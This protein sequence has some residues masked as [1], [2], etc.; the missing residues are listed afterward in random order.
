MHYTSTLPDI[1][2][3]R[4][5][6][7]D[8]WE[9]DGRRNIVADVGCLPLFDDPLRCPIVT[10]NAR[11]DQAGALTDVGV[12][13][14][15]DIDTT[16]LDSTSLDAGQARELA[17]M[18]LAAADLADTWTGTPVDADAALMVAREQLET[19]SRALRTQPGN[20]GCW[21]K[22]ALDAVTEAQAVLR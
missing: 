17:A 2:P 16:S 7:A 9:Q 22:A 19:A 10:T 20:A 5:A 12:R 6:D 15:V 13:L 11:Q 3:P 8:V 18:L 4:G 1:A 14:D 21:T